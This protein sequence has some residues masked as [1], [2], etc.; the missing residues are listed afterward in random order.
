VRILLSGY[1]GYDNAGDEAVLAAMLDHLSTRV[2]GAEFVVTSGDARATEM[3][4]AAEKYQLRAVSR[5]DFK[6]LWGEI[7]RCDL[8]LSGGGSLLQDATSLRNIVYYTTLIRFANIARKPAMVYAQGIGPLRRRVS[9]K[10][11]R[12]A[13]QSR[14][15]RIVTVR[16]PDSKAL[17]EH[18][19]V[20]REIEVTADPVWALNCKLQIANC[21]LNSG[22]AAPIRNSTWCVSLRSWLDA[23][24]P[25]AEAKL[26]QAVRSVAKAH[27]ATLKFLAMQPARDGALL[28]Q[29]GVAKEEMLPTG[30]L[31]PAEIMKV[32]GACGL[33]IGMRLHALI[34]AA[35][36][37]VPCVAVSYDPKVTSLAKLIGAPVI[38]NASD[39]E[40][41]KL[42]SV[43]MS[44]PAPSTALIAEMQSKAW[45]NAELAAGLL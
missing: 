4:H 25:D 39:D 44:A 18:I 32:A 29:L 5:A 2:A 37:G 10:L 35:A 36:Q 22:A 11:T 38:E 15:T 3:R 8:F 20:R 28:E 16:D 13:L 33:M 1:Y 30:N 12:A 41:A 26:L 9:Q 31:H 40:L 21:K 45:R 7:K 14:S 42:Q 24:T 43:A 17:L 23:S 27:G 34:F 6:T 19:G